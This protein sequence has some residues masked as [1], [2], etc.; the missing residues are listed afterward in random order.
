MFFREYL[1]KTGERRFEMF[2]TKH[3]FGL[4][5]MSQSFSQAFKASRSCC[6]IRWSHSPLISR[7]RTK[8]SANRRTDDLT[9]WGRS[10]MNRRKRVG[11]KTVPCHLHLLCWSVY[12]L[13]F[14]CVRV[15]QNLCTSR[16]KVCTSWYGYEK[17]WVWVDQLQS[18]S[19][20]LSMSVIVLVL[21]YLFVTYRAALRRTDSS[22]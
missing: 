11:L 6:K 19:S 12:E 9:R 4:N 15:D 18:Y 7:K 2:R 16:P 22:L 20:S 10:F 8:S 14:R 3:L 17:D 5:S 21:W 1:F 13:T